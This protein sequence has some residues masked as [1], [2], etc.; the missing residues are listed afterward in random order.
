MKN[1]ILFI[2]VSLTLSSCSDVSRKD[3]YD[4]QSFVDQLKPIT[5][6][7]IFNSREDYSFNSQPLKDSTFLRKIQKKHDGFI[8]F[9]LLFKTNEFIAVLGNL[10]TDIGSPFILTFDKNGEELDSYLVYKN[11]IGDMGIY[12]DNY[13]TI[14]PDFQIEQIDSTIR[15]KINSDGS[16]EIP[17]TDSLT[18]KLNK[19][20][21]NQNG[22]FVMIE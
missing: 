10:P 16:D 13:V 8:L 3:K 17:G 6:P 5:T 7:L 21:I 12:I 19:Y 9:G 18:V 4:F 14:N 15:R 20:K 11:V 22:K 1:H 2:L